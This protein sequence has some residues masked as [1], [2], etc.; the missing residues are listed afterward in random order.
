MLKTILKSQ[1]KNPRQLGPRLFLG[2]C[3]M[4]GCRSSSCT[5]FRRLTALLLLCGTRRSRCCLTGGWGWRRKGLTFFMG[6]VLCARWWS[7]GFYFADCW[8]LQKLLQ[9]FWKF[10]SFWF[11]FVQ[12]VPWRTW[13]LRCLLLTLL[14]LIIRAKFN[15][16]MYLFLTGRWIKLLIFGQVDTE[17]KISVFFHECVSFD[18][19]DILEFYLGSFGFLWF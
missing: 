7:N 12:L 17:E 8:R 6:L 10:F 18:S 15:K 1:L 16:K 3:M 2:L 14:T 9:A 19:D 13:V 11:S 4:C 5:L